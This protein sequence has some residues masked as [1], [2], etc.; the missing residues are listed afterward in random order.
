MT[1]T[2]YIGM[3]VHKESISIAVRN[4]PDGSSLFVVTYQTANNARS[5][6]LTPHEN[7]GH[8]ITIIASAVHD[9]TF[10]MTNIQRPTLG[11]GRRSQHDRFR[12]LHL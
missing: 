6:A 8:A 11:T 4:E 7:G 3:D 5:T 1:S 9:A 12:H 2:K 10:L